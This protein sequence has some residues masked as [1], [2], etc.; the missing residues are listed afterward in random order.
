MSEPALS[1]VH[2]VRTETRLETGRVVEHAQDRRYVVAVGQT[3]H[4]AEQAFG[5]LVKPEPGDK[6]LV[7]IGDETHILTIL[8]RPEDSSQ[9]IVFSGPAAIK[10]PH[11]SLDIDSAHDVRLASHQSMTLSSG[12]LNVNA[13]AAAMRVDRLSWCS[14]LVS[15]Q[16]KQIRLVAE[17]LDTV[18][19]RAVSRF[20]DA[21]RYVKRHDEL[22]AK[23]SRML[24]DETLTMHTGHTM[25][26]AKGH[27]KIDAEQIH[28]G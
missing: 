13:A 1:L 6:V 20:V 12:E 22:Q 16:A 28:V 11:G 18:A 2:S 15:G 10:A 9:E 21:F 25:H 27:V 23:S 5:C 4:D 24:V 7:S 19:R 3:R 26:T 8:S 17:S 14:R